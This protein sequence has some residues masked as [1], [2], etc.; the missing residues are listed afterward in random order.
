MATLSCKKEDGV[1]DEPNGK[2]FSVELT[3]NMSFDVQISVDGKMVDALGVQLIIWPTSNSYYDY[4]TLVWVLSRQQDPLLME[5]D[6]PED[7]FEMFDLG[8][9][10]IRLAMKAVNLYPE[11][12]GEVNDIM[13]KLDDENV[14]EGWN[15]GFHSFYL[16]KGEVYEYSY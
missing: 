13:E 2:D 4:D 10:S 15:P 11:R 8:G 1:I 5:F 16:K 3:H 9:D 12:Q 6:I 14:Q 7:K